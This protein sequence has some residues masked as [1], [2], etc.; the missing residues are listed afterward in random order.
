VG[1]TWLGYAV[2]GYFDQWAALAN[3]AL[4]GLLLL[5]TLMALINRRRA[6]ARQWVEID[7]GISKA[8]SYFVHGHEYAEQGKW[9]LA[10][11]HWERAVALKPTDSKWVLAL[12]EA[13]IKLGRAADALNTVE[14]GL[15]NQPDAP[16]A[17]RALAKQ[18]KSPRS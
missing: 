7:G 13:Q 15:A 4:D 1:W 12:A 6:R 8:H 14:A 11:V 3:V 5:F 18:L 10:I 16:A 17:L 2:L 9:A